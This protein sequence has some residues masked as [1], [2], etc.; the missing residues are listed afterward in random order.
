MDE[1]LRRAVTRARSD[2]DE[3]AFREI[4]TRLRAGLRRFFSRG[5]WPAD[6]ADDL[7]QKTLTRVFRNMGALASVD[8][9]LPWLFAIARNVRNRA[10][11]DGEARRRAEPGGLDLAGDPPD[12]SPGARPEATT[13]AREQVA[14]LREALECLPARQRQC[15]LLR[16]RDGLA[17]E[18][19]ATLL[20]LSVN[21]VRNH[22]AQARATLRRPGSDTGG[23]S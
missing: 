1:A 13:M 7:V 5:P 18:E 12:E 20:R 9:F 8:A 11:A 21:T 23:G 2:G 17:Y 14:A 10:A 4:D 3:A 16:A 6:E 19:I 15:L 22:I